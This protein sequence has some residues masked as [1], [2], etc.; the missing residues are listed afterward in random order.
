MRRTFFTVSIGVFVCCLLAI[1]LSGHQTPGTSSQASLH[2]QHSYSKLVGNASIADITLT[3]TVR[4]TAGSDDETG[5][6]VLKALATG[7]ARIDL[8]FPSGSHSEVRANSDKGPV[9]QWTG[10]D[11]VSHEIAYHN[12]QQD[13]SWFFPALLLQR[14]I[15][16]SHA[17]LA[18]AGSETRDGRIVEHLTASR[19]YSGSHLPD[20]FAKLLN[21]ASQVEVYIDSS[22][23]LPAAI[24]FDT[25]PDNDMLRDIPVE[26]RFSDYRIV[27]GTQVPFHVQ[28]FFGSGLFL[29]LQFETVVFNSGVSAASFNIQ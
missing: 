11:G 21:H 15:S 14:L 13:S 5:T 6:A 10:L 25:H 23:L 26:I 19:L 28:K 2:L 17:A 16:S 27:N 3:G 9:G 22:T 12:L 24:A 20:N 18:D 7:E 29:D 8:T 4:R 1:S